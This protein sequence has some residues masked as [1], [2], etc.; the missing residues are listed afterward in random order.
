M[1]ATVKL[2]RHQGRRKPQH[3]IND[4]PGLRGRLALATGG[5]WAELR[6]ASPDLRQLEPLALLA[7]ARLVTLHG[8]TLHFRGIEY[9][10]DGTEHVQ[11]WTARARGPHA[12]AQLFVAER[13][14]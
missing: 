7:D 5:G 9:G 14:D 10:P 3:V 6:L 4:E 12:Q 2:L 8:D 13:P 1:E 11:E